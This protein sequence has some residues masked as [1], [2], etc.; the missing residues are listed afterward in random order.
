V[1]QPTGHRH[2]RSRLSDD[3]RMSAV[4]DY[5]R[6]VATLTTAIPPSTFDRFR[7]AI[8]HRS[9]PSEVLELVRVTW[10]FHQMRRA[11]YRWPPGRSRA[12]RVAW[13][14]VR[15]ARC[16]FVAATGRGAPTLSAGCSEVTGLPAES[17][18]AVARPRR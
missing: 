10:L 8:R 11:T 12:R 16:G 5:A 14:R 13:W 3:A 1:T 6:A 18:S 15:S 2:A 17:V 7:Y 4:L 9:T